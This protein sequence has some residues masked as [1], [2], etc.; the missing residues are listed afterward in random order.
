MKLRS[1]TLITFL[2]ICT[3]CLFSDAPQQSLQDAILKGDCKAVQNLL[4]DNPELV[5]ATI[6]LRNKI[7]GQYHI[8]ALCFA[9]QQR[10][11]EIAK[12][13]LSAGAD[14]ALN[15]G[16][17]NLL[18]YPALNGDVDLIHLL[19][20]KGVDPNSVQQDPGWYPLACA[21]DVETA[22][23]LLDN[24]ANANARYGGG[25]TP[26]ISKVSSGD[27]NVILLLIK[28]GADVNAKDSRGCAPLNRAS[29]EC[30]PDMVRL[31]ID[32]GADVNAQ[33]NKGRNAL[34]RTI[35][36]R[37]SSRFGLERPSY[38]DTLKM[39][40]ANGSDADVGDLV[41]A[42]DL[43]RLKERLEKQPELIHTYKFQNNS[44]LTIA[45][46]HGHADI[47]EYLIEHGADIK[48]PGIFGNPLLHLAAFAGNPDTVELLIN[49]GLDVNQKGRHGELPLH[50]VSKM[51][52]TNPYRRQC[53]Y[54]Q[55][56][57]ILIDAGS[58]VN[59]TARQAW[60]SIDVGVDTEEP[61]DQ[62][63]HYLSNLKAR[64][65]SDNVQTTIPPQLAFDVGDTPLHSAARWGRIEIVNML[66]DAGAQIDPK[67]ALNQTPLHYA[68]VYQ[69]SEV[70]KALLK[71]G[72]DPKIKTN[73]DID[74]SQF[75]EIIENPDIIFL[76]EKKKP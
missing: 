14:P 44:L 22:Q 1:I 7:R 41:F 51:P 50:W 57:K 11:P 64:R 61:I 5:N 60:I 4:K 46:S 43:N 53:H 59:A 29:R 26:L 55:I 73:K 24:G 70:V 20:Q 28:N 6:E 52:N 76:L 67:N 62:I 23:A 66:I 45:V 27:K 47:V 16:R 2:L 75:A 65:A 33:D 31:L 36:E 19:V 10:Q 48:S 42:G 3:S 40:I 21:K 58:D 12:L 15:P 34:K 71:A 72:A 56:A 30:L 37:S 18:C 63:S 54:D 38:Y 13:L 17:T 9:L 25:T 8:S 35:E 69:H 32:N 49:K 74:A 39:L 68:V